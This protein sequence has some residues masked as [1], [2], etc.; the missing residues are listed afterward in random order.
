MA[1]DD[2]L[3]DL[4]RK[5]RDLIR[6]VRSQYPRIGLTPFPGSTVEELGTEVEQLGL[7]AKALRRSEEEARARQEWEEDMACQEAE[8]GETGPLQVLPDPSA[9]FRRAKALECA[10]S[11]A[12]SMEWKTLDRHSLSRE[13]IGTAREFERYLRGEGS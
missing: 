7:I 4:I 12:R 9:E 1:E 5:R 11:W 2:E 10:V 8:P 13:I 6:E 3:D